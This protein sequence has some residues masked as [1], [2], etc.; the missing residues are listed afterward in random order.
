MNTQKKDTL[1]EKEVADPLDE[2]LEFL[3]KDLSYSEAL[4]YCAD[5]IE[6]TRIL[7]KVAENQH[8]M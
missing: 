6:L 1:Y 4:E 7:G 2:A 3:I 8:L 5:Q